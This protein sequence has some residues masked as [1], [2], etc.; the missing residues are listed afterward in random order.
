M[1]NT[2]ELLT[3]K[4]NYLEAENSLLQAKYGAVLSQKLLNFYQNQSIE[5]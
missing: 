2:V 3:E 1:K 4:D 5:L